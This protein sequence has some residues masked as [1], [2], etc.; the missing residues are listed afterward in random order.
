MS[1]TIPDLLLERYR[2]NEL[3]EADMQEIERQAA[4]NPALRSRIGALTESDAEIRGRYAPEM[5]V[6]D[7]APRR[8]RVSG[9]VLAAALASAVLAIVIALP[10]LPA[11]VPDTAR[12][13]G[14]ANGRP[15]LA[16]YRRIADGSERLADGDV[17]RPGDL[18]RVG[19]VSAGRPYGVIVSIDGRG[20]VTL[21]LPPAG[22]RA[23]PLSQGGTVL[24]D[25]A[26]ELDDAPRIERFYFITGAHPFEVG[27]ILSAARAVGTAPDVLPL[28]PGLEQVTFAIQKEARK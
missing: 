27:P 1:R 4:G 17:A 23:A 15:V 28:A 16:V 9:L 5:F 8:S 3:P 25:A 10:R 13:K 2:L 26:Y 22:N 6:P 21:H 11:S 24:L 18:L 12:V 20:S 14:V 19:Y 7:R